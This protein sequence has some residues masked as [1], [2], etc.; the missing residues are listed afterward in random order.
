MPAK[1]AALTLVELLIIVALLATLSLFAAPVFSDL[2]QKNKNEALRNILTAQLT[3][4]RT[5]SIVHRGTHRLCG[6]SDGLRCDGDWT[7][8]LLVLDAK[9]TP[10]SSHQLPAGSDLCWRGF[11]R[12][13]VFRR[14]G[15]APTSN[16]RFELCQAGKAVWTLVL[17]RQGRARYAE[18]SSSEGCCV[19]NRTAS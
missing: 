9:S 19:T 15:T 13:V 5:A 3:H 11:S 12:E 10:V 14:N 4:A 2:R 16:G 17:N 18:P 6:S 8:H 7:S 1:Q